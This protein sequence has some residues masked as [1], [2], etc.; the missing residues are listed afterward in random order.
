MTVMLAHF[1]SLFYEVL[2]GYLRGF[3][4]SL[5]PAILTMLGV[6][7]IR[8]SWIYWVFPKDPTFRTIMLAFPISLITTALLMLCAVLYY[9][10][11]RRF[12]ALQRHEGE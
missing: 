4:I 6:C 11:T 8:L 12:A 5:P 1:A 3:S 9:R 10:P 7:G 2:S